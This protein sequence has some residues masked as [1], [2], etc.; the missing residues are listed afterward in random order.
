MVR[1]ADVVATRIPKGVRVVGDE[2]TALSAEL[3]ERYG[4]GE[5]IRLIAQ[6]IGR[7]YGFVHEILSQSDIPMRGRGGPNRYRDRAEAE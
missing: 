2:R 6:D 1:R 5:S 4:A 3:S 7:S